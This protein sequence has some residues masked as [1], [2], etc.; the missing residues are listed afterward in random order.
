MGLVYSLIP[1]P[2]RPLTVT[3]VRAARRLLG[4]SRDRLAG[5]TNLSSAAIANFENGM[6]SSF[7]TP[8]RLDII[9]AALEAAGAEFTD[10]KTPWVTMRARSPDTP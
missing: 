8:E 6:L 2:A 1:K 7:M 10:G 3:Q 4:W 9:R 5:A